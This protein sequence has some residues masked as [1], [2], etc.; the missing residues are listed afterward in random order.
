MTTRLQQ[1][2]LRLSVLLKGIYKKPYL[3]FILLLFLIITVIWLGTI[4]ILGAIICSPIILIY[5]IWDI[6]L[7]NRRK[8]K[9]NRILFENN[10]KNE[11]TIQG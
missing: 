10:T 5:F 8:K 6:I 11:D 3:S 2:L 7:T 4:I 9:L 1:L